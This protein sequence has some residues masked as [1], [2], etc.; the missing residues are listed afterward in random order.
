MR[1]AKHLTR[2]RRTLFVYFGLFP[3]KDAERALHVDCGELMPEYSGVAIPYTA[4]MAQ[5]EHFFGFVPRVEH[6]TSN[7]SAFQLAA[8]DK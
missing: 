3:S 5:Y 7:A 4:S 6:I 1:N 2:N 8:P